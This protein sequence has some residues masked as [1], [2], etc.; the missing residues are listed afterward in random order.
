MTNRD[1]AFEGGDAAGDTGLHV[2][3]LNA[4]R[5]RYRLALCAGALAATLGAA[6]GWIG[7][8]PLYQSNGMIRITPLMARLLYTSQTEQNAPP[9]APGIFEAFVQSQVSIIRS[10]QLI[11]RV[12]HSPEW[13][14]A[15]EASDEQAVARFWRRFEVHHPP[16]PRS[17][18]KRICRVR[19][20]SERSSTKS[21]RRSQAL[22]VAMALRI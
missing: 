18:P 8:E 22:Q 21:T 13:K 19:L 4:L 11:D 17:V 9:P 16:A 20:R 14:K 15:G 5:G 10:Q 2:Y 1:D 7:E 12:M 6:F 3:V